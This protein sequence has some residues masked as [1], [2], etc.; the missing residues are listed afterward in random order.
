[1]SKRELGRVEV[2]ARVRSRELRVVDAARLLRVSYRQA[3]RLWKRYGEE[4]AAGLKHRS[5]GRRSN[6][7]YPERLRR[8]VLGLVREKYG[9]PVGER[10]GP[11]LAAEHL[12]SED[13]LQVDA[14][15]LR[16]WML[17]E[18]LWSRERKRRR[19]RR[20]RE[21]KAHFG[22]MVQ[23]DGSFHRWLE[24]RGPEGCLM[25]LVDDAT[26]TTLARLG[27][28]ETIWAA[29]D[30]LRAW[31]ER[32]GVP[33][34][35]YVD[36]KNLY[37]RG[38]TVRERLRGEE[39]ITQFGR[40]CAKL[41]TELIAASSPQ[42]KGRVERIHGTHQDRLV[43][44]LRRKKIDTHAQANAYLEAEYLAEHNRRFARPAARPEDYHRRAPR[45][46]ELDRIFRLESER[47]ISD[48]WVV[49]Y[50]NRLFQLEPESRHYAPAEGQVRVWEGRDGSLAIEYRGRRLPWR[51]IESP[52]R[53]RAPEATP[54]SASRVPPARAVAQIAK[55]KWVPPANHPWRQ[56]ARAHLLSGSGLRSALN[57]PPFGLRRAPRRPEPES[58]NHQ[59]ASEGTLLMR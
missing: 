16:R 4:G 51:E 10:F 22:E 18:G 14:E 7:A 39:P 34:A 48:D 49:R 37:K 13:G 40:M 2:L 57:A 50:D 23:M 54:P 6:R 20:R 47:T 17:G 53:P 29:A 55:R 27:E 32:Y 43:K 28:Q 41:G 46:A 44:K 15:T 52:A 1:M 30:A 24:E 9:G 42:A 59:T 36:W 58:N 56:A 26:G 21:R 25:D 11:T 5:A 45:A 3:K 33:L 31:I 12:A 19:H 8:K 38:A 35:L